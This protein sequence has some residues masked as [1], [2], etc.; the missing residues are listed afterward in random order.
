MRET[1]AIQVPTFPH[2]IARPGR[3]VA[4]AIGL[5]VLAVLVPDDASSR[6]VAVSGLAILALAGASVFLVRRAGRHVQPSSGRLRS[7]TGVVP[8]GS[9]IDL[10]LDDL[11][12]DD[13]ALDEAVAERA[14]APAVTALEGPA[15]TA[16]AAPVPAIAAVPAVL[17]ERDRAELLVAGGDALHEFQAQAAWARRQRSAASSLDASVSDLPSPRGT[18]TPPD[19]PDSPPPVT[20]WV[21]LADDGMPSLR[22]GWPFGPRT[23]ERAPSERPASAR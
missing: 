6:W 2:R 19:A 3:L 1:T 12:L 15:V 22:S 23:G 17:Q 11:A 13:L 16:P 10:A 9:S 18:V 4:V 7:G 5:G 21:P 20:Q 8:T 14:A